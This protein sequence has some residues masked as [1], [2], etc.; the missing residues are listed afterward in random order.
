MTHPRG[1][2]TPPPKSG[3]VQQKVTV[4][5]IRA[6]KRKGE[7]ITV[8]TAYDAITARLV[9][10]A[11]VDIILVGDSLG[12]VVLGY[13]TT[14]P[15]TMA[16]MIHHARAVR[17]GVNRALV[18]ADMPFGSFQGSVDA[19]V[20]NAVRLLKEARADAVKLEGGL[21]VVPAIQR[22]VAM[23][24]PVMGHV[25]LTPQSVREFGGFKV[26]GRDDEEGQRLVADAQA[27]AAAGAFSIVIEGVPAALGGAITAAVPVPTIGIGAGADCDGQ[28]LV[29]HD[30]LGL[31][32]DFKPKFV[33]RYA[34]LAGLATDAVKTFCREVRAGEFPG[35]E[36]FYQ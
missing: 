21:R 10:E 34:N 13:E 20:D 8:L 32:Q 4:P 6:M 7:R 35:T 22:M 9:D 11:G 18:V 25:G 19:A 24:I 2:D 1:N 12:N 23:G 15:V 28:V 27:L 33:K 5:M 26:Q 29:L 36:H 31:S 16:D 14:L 30:M 3:A 17:R